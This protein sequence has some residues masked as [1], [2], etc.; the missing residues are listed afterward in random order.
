MLPGKENGLQKRLV[1][2]IGLWD[3]VG[4]CGDI[5]F[6]GETAEE[7]LF[8]GPPLSIGAVYCGK[9]WNA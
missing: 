3:G 8:S 2:P 5:S 6:S 1:I 4:G 7:F 9:E